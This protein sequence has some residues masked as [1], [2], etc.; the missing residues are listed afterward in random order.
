MENP[1]NLP[2]HD[3]LGTVQWHGY[4]HMLWFYNLTL[5]HPR[6]VTLG[7]LANLSAPCFL[8]KTGTIMAKPHGVDEK[9]Y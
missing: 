1:S 3:K 2:H 9:A 4:K 5:P 8:C 7:K 6:C